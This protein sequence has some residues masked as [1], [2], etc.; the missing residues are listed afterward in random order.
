MEYDAVSCSSCSGLGS[1]RPGRIFNKS[2]LHRQ[3]GLVKVSQD[4]VSIAG[5]VYSYRRKCVE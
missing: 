1:G 2:L 3:V 4:Q 5:K